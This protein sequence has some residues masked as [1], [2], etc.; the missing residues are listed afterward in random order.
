MESYLSWLTIC[1]S[2]SPKNNHHHWK[3]EWGV[4]VVPVPRYCDN[5]NNDD[6][7]NEE[8]VQK[9]LDHKDYWAGDDADDDDY[10]TD[11]TDDDDCGDECAGDKEGDAG[12]AAMDGAR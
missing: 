9:K 2:F 8:T 5:D 10:G 3:S 11:D 4:C 1:E 7:F 6:D 12:K